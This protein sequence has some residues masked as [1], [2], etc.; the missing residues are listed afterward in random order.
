MI[1]PRLH[2]RVRPLHLFLPLTRAPRLLLFRLPYLLM[3]L[4]LLHIDTP[5]I[6]IIILTLTIPLLLTTFR[7]AGS[8]HAA[9]LRLAMLMPRLRNT[10]ATPGR[11]RSTTRT[12]VSRSPT[13]MA[14]IR[15]STT[16][17]LSRIYG[18][19]FKKATP[20]FSWVVK[21][22]SNGQKCLGM[23]NFLF[24]FVLEKLFEL[25][26]ATIAMRRTFRTGDNMEGRLRWLSVH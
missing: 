26:L 13:L 8:A 11:A 15:M 2:H 22:R 17:P 14:L 6:T 19:G 25:S 24:G 7:Q 5:I 18:T 1:L 20:I 16:I 3:L 10:L 9:P 23:G 12:S 4:L 21:P